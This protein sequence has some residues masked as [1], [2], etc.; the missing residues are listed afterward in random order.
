MDLPGSSACD[1]ECPKI[2]NYSQCSPSERRARNNVRLDIM[3]ES[4]IHGGDEMEGRAR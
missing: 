1:R 4:G 3:E 2:Y